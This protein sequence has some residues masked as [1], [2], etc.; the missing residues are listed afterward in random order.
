[1]DGSN[2]NGDIIDCLF[3]DQSFSSLERHILNLYCEWVFMDIL[4]NRFAR[5]LREFCSDHQDD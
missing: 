5:I 1:M 3:P 2:S 4:L